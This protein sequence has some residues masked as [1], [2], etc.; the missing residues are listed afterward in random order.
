MT[1]TN[2][3][4]RSTVWLFIL[5]GFLIFFQLPIASAKDTVSG[6]NSWE[7]VVTRGTIRKIS[8]EQNTLSLKIR[9]GEKIR[10][11]FSPQTKFIGASSLGDLE[12]G[13][14]VKVWH[15]TDGEEHKVLKLELLPDLGC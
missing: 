13:Q 14:Q 4:Q 3:K 6:I 1:S 10:L 9:K 5:A 8:V 7:T 11:L 2:K 15:T 12:R